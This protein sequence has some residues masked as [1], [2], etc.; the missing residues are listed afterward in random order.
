MAEFTLVF[1]DHS[2]FSHSVQ[3]QTVQIFC[4]ICNLD[5]LFRRTEFVQP[6]QSMPGV[7]AYPPKLNSHQFLLKD[8]ILEPGTHTKSSELALHCFLWVKCDHLISGS[9]LS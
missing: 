8:W 4:G 9:S 3:I 7:N 1:T 6:T 2:V 5:I